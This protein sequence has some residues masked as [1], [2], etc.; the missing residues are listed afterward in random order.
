M[1]HNKKNI[2]IITGRYGK[3]TPSDNEI[4]DSIFGKGYA[5]ERFELYFHWY[6]LIH[7]LGHGIIEFNSTSRLHPVKEEQLVNDFA[8]AYWTYYGEKEK[9]DELDMIVSYALTHLKRPADNLTHIEY[10]YNNWGKEELMNFNNYGWFQFSCVKNSLSEKKPIE[11]VLPQMGVQHVMPRVQQVLT[12]TLEG[13]KTSRKI[14]ED[15]AHILSKWGV[16]LSNVSV[17][18]DDDP[19]KHMCTHIDA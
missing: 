8:V 14:V 19:N 16:M 11:S 10:A 15:A 4:V 1:G 13:E 9:L 17:A 3:G 12:Y 5:R 18:F 2:L 6:N 7:E